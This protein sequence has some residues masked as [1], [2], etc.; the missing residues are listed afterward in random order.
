M[1]IITITGNLVADAQVKARKDSNGNVTGEFV[2]FK[3]ACNNTFGEVKET[4]FYEVT[5]RK[6]GVFEYLK[7]GQ[8]VIVSGSLRVVTNQKENGTAYT[9]LHIYNTSVLELAGKKGSG[10]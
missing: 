7:R 10:E 2:T 8:S 3:V 6:T 9:N 1:Q 4:S 5:Y